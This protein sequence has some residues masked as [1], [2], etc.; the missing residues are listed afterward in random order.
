[1]GEVG[2]RQ[3]RPEPGRIGTWIVRERRSPVPRHAD[4]RRSRRTTTIGVEE[5]YIQTL[6]LSHGFSIKAGRFFSAIGYLN[7]ST[8]TRGTS[9]T[10]RSPNKVF[11]GNQLSDDG[12]QVKWV[13][14]TDLYWDVGAGSRGAA[15]RSRPTSA[16]GATRTASARTICSPTSA[17]T[18]AR[19][20]PG[21]RDSRTCAPRRR[22]GPTTTSIRPAPRSPT[23]SAA[24]P[25]CGC[26]TAS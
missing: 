19:A 14:P 3:A 25:A 22:T 21:R 23:A 24:S 1:M 26:S 15:A 13:A 18:S 5:G 4:R 9:P 10:R 8:R 12:I 11:L 6:G 16:A 7:R 17:A 2:P 20:L